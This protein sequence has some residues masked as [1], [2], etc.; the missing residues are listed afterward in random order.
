MRQ[1]EIARLPLRALSAEQRD[2]YFRNGYVVLER[3][4]DDGRLADLRGAMADLAAWSGD[5]VRATSDFEFEATEDGRRLRQVLCASDHH[6][7]IWAYASDSPLTDAVADL[8]GP[9]V[10]FRE[11]NVAFKAPGGRGFAWHQDIVFF[12]ASNLS[13]LMTLTFLDDVT[14]EMGPTRV[15]PGSHR[16]HVFDHYDA[17][18]KWLGVIGDHE[19]HLV[20]EPEAVEITAPAGSVLVTNCA[21]VHAASPN[22]GNRSRPVVIAGYQS[23]DAVCYADVPYRSRYKWAIV[24]GSASPYVHSEA[25]TWKMPPDWSAHHGIRI[26]N[27]YQQKG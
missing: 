13:L 18:G 21:L 6:P 17:S 2:F 20:R 10:K 24:R 3:F 23:A 1:D 12:P 4:L 5:P 8:V 16:G 25:V 7:A 26:D 14:P 22:R 15:I 11:S 9:D 27:L 19:K